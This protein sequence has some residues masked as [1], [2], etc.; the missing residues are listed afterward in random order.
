MPVAGGLYRPQNYDGE[1]KGLV[2]VRTALASSLNVPAVR[3]LELVGAEAALGRLRR[4]GFD[5]LD[6]GRRLLRAV[7]GAGLADVS[8]WELVGAYRA[9]A[10]GGVWSPLALRPG[11]PVARS[12]AAPRVLGGGGLAGRPRARRPREPR[13]RPSAWRTRSPPGSGPR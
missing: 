10:N 12:H 7:A 2:S 9:L 4:L 1:F 5:G 8:L 3:A 11:A 13:A 6:G